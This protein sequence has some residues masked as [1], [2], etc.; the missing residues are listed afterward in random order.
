MRIADLPALP[1]EGSMNHLGGY[2]PV[3][4]AGFRH[5]IIRR[6]GDSTKKPGTAFTEKQSPVC[7]YLVFSIF[8]I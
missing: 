2:P 5:G 3:V 8:F 7:V 1:D 4:K 6:G